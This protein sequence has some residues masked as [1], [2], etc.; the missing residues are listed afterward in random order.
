V[1]KLAT[2][3]SNSVPAGFASERAQLYRVLAQVSEYTMTLLRTSVTLSVSCC[4]LFGWR[5][6][7]RLIE[8]RSVHRHIRLRRRQQHV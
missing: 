3:L 8:L 6:R 5:R 4:L 1:A 2:V 7:G